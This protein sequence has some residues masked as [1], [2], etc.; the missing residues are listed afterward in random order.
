MIIF[1]YHD[2]LEIKIQVR[3]G[4]TTTC[5]YLVVSREVYWKSPWE[6]RPEEDNK[7]EEE[8]RLTS[9]VL[10]KRYTLPYMILVRFYRVDKRGSLWTRIFYSN[11]WSI[12]E[13]IVP[14]VE[15]VTIKVLWGSNVSG[16][17]STIQYLRQVS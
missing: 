10:R 8:S 12:T 13:C 9:V 2:V 14:I 16:W 11:T 4:R 5:K 15:R 7:N 1:L 3:T 6:N 17:V